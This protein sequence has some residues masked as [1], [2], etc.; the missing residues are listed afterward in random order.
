MF[1]LLSMLLVTEPDFSAARDLAAAEIAQSAG[2]W[3]KACNYLNHALNTQSLNDAGTAMIYWGLSMCNI[4][5]KK[6]DETADALMGFIIY[7]EDYIAYAKSLKKP[8][9]QEMQWVIDFKLQENLLYAK[10]LSQIYWAQRNDYSCRNEMFSCKVPKNLIYMF[11]EMLPFCRDISAIKKTKITV[12]DKLTI[13]DVQ[14]DIGI[15]TY[16]FT[17]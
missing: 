12:K 17:K 13:V 16:Y 5:L 7:A 9:G 3:D 10:T 4:C 6:V 15:E 14:C 11:A 8:K 1:I 2:E